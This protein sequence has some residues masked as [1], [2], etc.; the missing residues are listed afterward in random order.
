[1]SRG[2]PGDARLTRSNSTNAFS[3]CPS[4]EYKT[5]ALKCSDAVTP[6]S[7]LRWLSTDFALPDC[8]CSKYDCANASTASGYWYRK[9]S[10]RSERRNRLG[11]VLLL[12]R[13]QAQKKL[14]GSSG[15]A[16]GFRQLFNSGTARVY[17][18]ELK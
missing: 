9:L 17:S 11:I 8:C 1:M 3:F 6:G 15:L 16:R 2:N 12:R 18:P 5:P 4:C 10:R 7:E 13:N 14:G